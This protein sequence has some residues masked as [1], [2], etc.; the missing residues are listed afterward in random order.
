MYL[1]M[2]VSVNIKRPFF[3]TT[4]LTLLA[5][6]VILAIQLS[7][8]QHLSHLPS[9]VSLFIKELFPYELQWTD[10]YIL[11]GRHNPKKIP[12]NFFFFNI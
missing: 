9:F 11:R 7:A 1:C 2:C 5:V 10:K 6:L 4:A 3:F 8:I 12:Y